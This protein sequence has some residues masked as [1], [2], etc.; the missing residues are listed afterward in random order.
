MAA[1]NRDHLVPKIIVNEVGVQTTVYV[2]PEEAQALSGK[3]TSVGTPTSAVR[4]TVGHPVTGLDDDD[5]IG[6]ALTTYRNTGQVRGAA[7]DLIRAGFRPASFDPS[8]K[9]DD[10]RRITDMQVILSNMAERHD[11]FRLGSTDEVAEEL[12]AQGWVRHV[13]VDT[14]LDPYQYT[15]EGTWRAKLHSIERARGVSDLDHEFV[16]GLAKDGWDGPN[17]REGL[18]EAVRSV[19]RTGGPRVS[20]QQMLDGLEGAGYTKAQGKALFEE[21]DPSEVLEHYR[22]EEVGEAHYVATDIAFELDEIN[23]ET[24]SRYGIKLRYDDGARWPT[25]VEG[26]AEHLYK[27]LVAHDGDQLK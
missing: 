27:F 12:K 5:A 24:E 6:F 7:H 1:L 16:D 11:A 17:G 20:E 2:R 25:G 26:D 14:N 9:R 13:G 18:A 22:V 15:T 4:A 3:L 21:Y 19:Y 10:D 23:G 8:N